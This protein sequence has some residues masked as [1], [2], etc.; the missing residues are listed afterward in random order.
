MFLFMRPEE[1][2]DPIAC[3]CTLVIIGCGFNGQGGVYLL[4]LVGIFFILRCQNQRSNFTVRCCTGY[5]HEIM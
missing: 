4:C 1:G 2:G 5:V 3:I